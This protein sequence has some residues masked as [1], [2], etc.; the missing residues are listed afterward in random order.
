[1]TYCGVGVDVP[2]VGGSGWAGCG[3]GVDGP[4]A[5]GPVEG[6]TSHF[7]YFGE[8]GQLAKIGIFPK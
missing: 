5:G 8:I 1:M 2:V 4:G 6:E 3:E 7:G